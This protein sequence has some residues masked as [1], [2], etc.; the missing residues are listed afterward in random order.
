[1]KT[2]WFTGALPDHGEKSGDDAACQK[3]P[4]TNPPLA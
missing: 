4:A 2:I 1:M 3:W